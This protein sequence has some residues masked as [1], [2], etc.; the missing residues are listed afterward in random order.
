MSR[1]REDRRLTS[2]PDVLDPGRDGQYD[3]RSDSDFKW[4][5]HGQ[6]LSHL[7]DAWDCIHPIT[8]LL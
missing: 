7:P 3:Q 5:L 4:L 2:W 6:I 8:L 1:I